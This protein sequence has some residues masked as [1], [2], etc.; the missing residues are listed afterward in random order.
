MDYIKIGGHAIDHKNTGN[1]ICLNH[2]QFILDCDKLTDSRYGGFLT[3][4]P[5]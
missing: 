2:A 1:S 5:K 4:T 3:I